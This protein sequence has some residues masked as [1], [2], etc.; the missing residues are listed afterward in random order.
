MKNYSFVFEQLQLIHSICLT[1][2]VLPEFTI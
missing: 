2:D 1:I